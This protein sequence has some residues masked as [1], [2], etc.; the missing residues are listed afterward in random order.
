VLALAVA[1][2]PPLLFVLAPAGGPVGGWGLGAARDWTGLRWFA[3]ASAVG[4][5]PAL[6]LARLSFDRARRWPAKA[7]AA[8]AVAAAL[9]MVPGAMIQIVW[10]TSG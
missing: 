10:W 2:I 7:P 1:C 6:I 4:L 8:L 9:A 5:G 3:L